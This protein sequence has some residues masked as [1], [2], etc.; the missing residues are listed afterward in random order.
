[1]KPSRPIP[2]AKDASSQVFWI[3]WF[4]MIGGIVLYQCKLGGGWLH[5]EDAR[6]AIASPITWV[7]IGLLLCAAAVRWLLIPQVRGYRPLLVLLI[8]GLALSETVGFF[9]MFLLP[10]D[11]PAAKMQLF[12]LALLS[13][14][15][16]AP[17][18]ARR[19]VRD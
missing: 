17:F 3:I 14:A 9:G 6:S 13:A 18:Y 4:G 1:M 11:M 7:A 19:A 10:A 16:F 8:I 15:Q 5:G 12:V 2:P